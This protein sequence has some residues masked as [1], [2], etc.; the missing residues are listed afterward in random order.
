MPA[1]R[2]RLATGLALWVVPVAELGGVARHVLDATRHGV[3]GWRIVVLCPDGPLA[4]RLAAQGTA[5]LRGAISPADGPR[6]AVRTLRRVLARLRPDLLHTHLAFADLSGVAAVTGL[7]SGRGARIRLVSTEHGISGVPGLYQSSPARARAIAA[8]H[9]ARLRRADRVIAVSASTREQIVAQWGSAEK[10]V[11]V[12][13]AVEPVGEIGPAAASGPTGASASTDAPGPDAPLRVLSLSRLAPEKRIDRAL[14]AFARVHAER[15][16]ATF[17]IAGTGPQEQRLRELARELGLGDAVSFVGHVE[18]AESMP[19]HDV[20]VQLSAWENLSY[21][22]LD[23]V[24][25]GL[26]VVATDVGGNREIL[27]EQC[28]VDSSR[29]E[30]VAHAILAQGRP[31]SIRAPRPDAGGVA[32]MCIGIAE[33]Y[34]EVSG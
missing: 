23:A 14:E 9:R 10:I 34:R 15:P 24:A 25:H 5:V 11:V 19:R 3:D 21:T 31:S 13:N 12:R 20:L 33:V 26:G 4:D 6:T 7:R 32:R 8:A 29:L 18:P 30:D 2:R 22:L 1:E 28:L 17:T 27:P 16:G